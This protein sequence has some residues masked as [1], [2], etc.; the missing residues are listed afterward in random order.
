MSIKVVFFDVDDTLYDHSYHVHYAISAIRE[1]YSFLQEY[2]AEHLKE[3]SHQFLEEVHERLLRG[4]VSIKE[5]RR[6]RWE[7][8][9]EAVGQHNL[10]PMSLANFYSRSYYEAERA[11]PGVIELLETLSQSYKIG[12]I[13]NNI[14]E[15]QLK[16]MHRIGISDYIETFAISEEVGAAKPDL[17]IFNTALNRAGV[18]SQEAIYIGDSWNNDILG[19]L[20]AGIRPLWFNRKGIPSPNQQISEISSFEPMENILTYIRNEIPTPQITNAEPAKL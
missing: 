19:A 2:S 18:T 14:F 4:E 3:L 6:V 11:V 16:K 15:E 12:V 9:I 10:D 17:K 5:S 8:F 1:K 7:K 13:S 20:N